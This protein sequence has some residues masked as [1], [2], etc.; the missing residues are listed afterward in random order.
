MPSLRDARRN[1]ILETAAKRIAMIDHVSIA[2][3]D[4]E[5]CGRFYDVR[6]SAAHRPLFASSDSG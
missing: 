5:A 2:V 1:E 4:L 6:C 3:R